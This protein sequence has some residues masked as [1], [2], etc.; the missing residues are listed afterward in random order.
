MRPHVIN[1]IP[2]HRLSEA[3]GTIV[4]RAW[5]YDV[6]TYMQKRKWRYESDF[7]KG[8]HLARFS[9]DDLSV[10]IR[11]LSAVRAIV[12]AALH[13]LEL[14][15]TL[16]DQTVRFLDDVESRLAGRVDPDVIRTELME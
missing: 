3:A 7:K 9:N 12:V 4:P 10:E 14:S 15:G 8:L 1:S 13:A 5:L 11:A 6:T 16:P 2:S